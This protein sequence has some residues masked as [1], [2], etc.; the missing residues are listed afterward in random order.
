MIWFRK[1]LNAIEY[2]LPKNFPLGVFAT[3]TAIRPIS[4]FLLPLESRAQLPG[5][6]RLYFALFYL[7]AGA[8]VCN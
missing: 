5:I 1:S 4:H 3:L 8:P 6:F 2:R 7:L